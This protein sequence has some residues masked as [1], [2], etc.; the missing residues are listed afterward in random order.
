MLPE[1]REEVLGKW[2][3][4]FPVLPMVHS[5]GANLLRRLKSPGLHRLRVCSI[6]Y[7]QDEAGPF[8]KVVHP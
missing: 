3:K 1:A 5:P 4:P 2:L 6:F 7:E 8:Y